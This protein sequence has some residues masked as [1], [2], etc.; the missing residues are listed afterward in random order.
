M[1]DV[2]LKDYHG[3]KDG[4]DYLINLIDSPG[5]QDGQVLFGTEG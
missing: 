1:S 3:K 2:A 4:N 5:E